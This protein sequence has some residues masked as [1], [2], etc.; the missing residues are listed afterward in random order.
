MRRWE[1]KLDKALR[2]EK[3][4][5]PPLK[6]FKALNT[7]LTI[8]EEYGKELGDDYWAV[9]EGNSYKEERG[10]LIDHDKVI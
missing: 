1:K 6:T 3:E 8:L 4:V 5:E 9:W 2:M 10:S 7:N